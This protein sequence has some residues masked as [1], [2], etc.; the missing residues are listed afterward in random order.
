MA[1][2]TWVDAEYGSAC[3]AKV[4]VGLYLKVMP[5][6]IGSKGA[7]VPFRVEVFAATLVKR[8]ADRDEAKA[9]AVS[10]AKLFLELAAKTFE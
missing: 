2:L 6:G 5:D 4:G 3:T 10:K 8:F 1:K 9:A 7:P